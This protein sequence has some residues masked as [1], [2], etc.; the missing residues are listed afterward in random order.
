[1]KFQ[2][3][4]D[5]PFEKRLEEGQNIRKK[6]PS[7]V[8]V[9]VEKSPRARVG[10]LEK[11]KYLVPSDLTV[12]QFYFLIRKKIQLNP[13]EALFFFVKDIIPPTSATMGALYQE[14]HDRDLFLYIAY[15]DESIYGS[16]EDC[17]S[18]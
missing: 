2:Y 7:S 13:E 5:R 18:S 14:H 16:V 11:N 8:P 4:E 1:M 9:I 6:Y 10:N 12:G 17:I 15:S 3:K